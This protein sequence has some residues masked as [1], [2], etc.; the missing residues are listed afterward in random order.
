[1]YLLSMKELFLTAI[2]QTREVLE[3]HF[4]LLC[5]FLS[6]CFHATKGIRLEAT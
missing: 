4:L 6:S 3:K 2:L 5:L 1:M